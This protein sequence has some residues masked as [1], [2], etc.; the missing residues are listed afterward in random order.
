MSD[1]K[2]RNKI[3]ADIFAASFSAPGELSNWLLGGDLALAR[4]ASNAVRAADALILE[5]KNDEKHRAPGPETV[6]VRTRPYPVNTR[7]KIQ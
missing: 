4:R 5:L 2:T 6:P 1:L 3:A 7:E